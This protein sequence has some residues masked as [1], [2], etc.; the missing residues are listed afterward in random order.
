MRLLQIEGGE[1]T[2]TD[3]VVEKTRMTTGTHQRGE[4]QVM[5]PQ[6]SRK[7]SELGATSEE[8]GNQPWCAMPEPHRDGGFDPIWFQDQGGATTYQFPQANLVL[9]HEMLKWKNNQSTRGRSIPSCE[10][11]PTKAARIREQLGASSWCG[12]SQ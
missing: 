2:G 8:D 1:G 10:A 6:G 7:Y 12:S 4:R 3:S 11:N 9:V 5:I